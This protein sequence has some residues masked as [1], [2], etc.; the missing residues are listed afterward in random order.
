MDSVINSSINQKTSK[1][2]EKEKC[3]QFVLV[4]KYFARSGWRLKVA[5]SISEKS[6]CIVWSVHCTVGNVTAVMKSHSVKCRV[7]ESGYN[8]RQRRIKGDIY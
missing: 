7:G 6:Q 8:F 5:N 4:N 3:I 1:N 2:K